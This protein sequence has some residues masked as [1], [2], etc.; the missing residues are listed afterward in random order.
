[1]Y[2]VIVQSPY[3]EYK[4]YGF[5]MCRGNFA[6]ERAVSLVML[7]ILLIDYL[8]YYRLWMIEGLGNFKSLMLISFKFDGKDNS[9]LTD[10][11]GW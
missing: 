8:L 4:V 2:E 6:G 11:S 10:C 9:A 7:R 1:M 5:S 3:F